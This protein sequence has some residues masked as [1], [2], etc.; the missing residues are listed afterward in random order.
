MKT[1]KELIK[2]IIPVV[3]GILIALFINNW[4]D[5]RKEEKY[6]NQIF[7]S[8]DKELEESI[9]DIK[10]VIPKQLK[11]VDTLQVYMNNDEVSLYTIMIKADGIHGP[12]IKTNSWNAIENSKIELVA[13][14][15]LSAL[16]DIEER[17]YGLTSRIEKQTDFI[18]Q[19]FE[20]TDKSK[21]EI[22]K[23]MIL[24]IIGTEKRLQVAIEESIKK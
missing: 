5:E 17:K 4:N 20:E 1:T 10:R 9:L 3:I 7:S 11:T 18:F 24:D 19:N 15:K 21:K 14:E 13:Y 8:I 16:A 2:E 23:M 12:T 6:L 22:L